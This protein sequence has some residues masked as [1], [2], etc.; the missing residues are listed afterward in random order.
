ML[1]GAFVAALLAGAPALAGDAELFAAYDRANSMDI[2][3]AELGAVRGHDP[4]VRALAVM[5]LRDHAGV[6]QLARDLAS[7]AGI[8]FDAGA[9]P[10][11][12]GATL[13]RLEALSGPAFDMAYLRHEAR[14]HARAIAAVKGEI[15]PAAALPALRDHLAAVLPHFEHHLAETLATA[16]ALGYEVE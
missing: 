4:R 10:D 16:K 12:H 14:F 8:S 6:R 3:T 5:V 15:L 9:L 13:A 2:E 1:R 11:D 7:G